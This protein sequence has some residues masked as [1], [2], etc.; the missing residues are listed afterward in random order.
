MKCRRGW[1]GRRYGWTASR[2]H[3]ANHRLRSPP[4][5]PWSEGRGFGRKTLEARCGPRPPRYGGRCRLLAWCS[6]PPWCTTGCALPTRT[7]WLRAVGWATAA[8]PP[9]GGLAG[10]CPHVAP[11]ECPWGRPTS[12][13]KCDCHR[14][15]P[16]CAPGSRVPALLAQPRTPGVDGSPGGACTWWPSQG[17]RCAQQPVWGFPT[18]ET[19][20]LGFDRFCA[21]S[22]CVLCWQSLRMSTNALV[23]LSLLFLSVSFFSSLPLSVVFDP[24]PSRPASSGRPGAS[25]WAPPSSL[26]NPLG[27]SPDL[28]PGFGRLT[29]SA[30]RPLEY[31]GG[32]KKVSHPLDR[33]IAAAGGVFFVFLELVP[34]APARSEACGWPKTRPYRLPAS[35]AGPPS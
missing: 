25:P 1:C 15:M 26:P 31:C 10:P 33:G 27:R 17:T 29:H 14:G 30:N 11:V 20:W 16:L 3:L 35:C 22:L 2:R 18:K 21:Y 23:Q 8:P 9:P 34:A 5:P 24:S 32:E 13:R 28:G 19:S 12:R 7:W 4:L 6:S